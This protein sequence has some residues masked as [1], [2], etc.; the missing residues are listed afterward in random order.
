MATYGKGEGRRRQIWDFGPKGTGRVL[1]RTESTEADVLGVS[2]VD[3]RRPV[4]TRACGGAAGED[5]STLIEIV[6]GFAL[7]AVVVLATASGIMAATAAA[8][9]A[10]Q[11]EVAATLISG[12]IAKIEALPFADVTAGLNPSSDSLSS[13]ANIQV[14]GSTY[15]LKLTGATLATT[16]T[17]TSDAPLVPHISTSTVDTLNYQVATYPEQSS[18]GAITVVVIVSWTSS[19][20]A[21]KAQMVGE[22]VVAT[23]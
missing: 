18:S 1:L 10:Q 9:T 14:S 15:T 5:G 2:E 17:K 7:L 8:A 12:D 6:V 20:D 23:P 3:G 4:S 16:N 21:T 11:R 22:T 19:I 13:D